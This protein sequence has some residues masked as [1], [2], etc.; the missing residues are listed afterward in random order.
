MSQCYLDAVREI[1]QTVNPL[2]TFLKARLTVAEQGKASIVMPLGPHLRQGGGQVAGG[3]LATMA[4]ECMAHAV[5]SLLD[6]CQTV[7]TA[8]MN[9]RYL[10]STN[11]D[12][13]GELIA[14]ANVVKNGRRLAV[15]EATV[16]DSNG[17][18]LATAG[19]TFDVRSGACEGDH[20]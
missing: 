19:A 11:P 16:H 20:G 1:D 6:P 9:I 4:D 2:F 15:A 7:V 18:L 5:L 10:R 3:I 8:E 12:Q 17:R 14:W 13:G